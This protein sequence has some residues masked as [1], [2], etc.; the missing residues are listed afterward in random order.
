M[1][2]RNLKAQTALLFCLITLFSYVQMSTP[3]SGLCEG[4]QLDWVGSNTTTSN[5]DIFRMRVTMLYDNGQINGW[6]WDQNG[7]V[8][9]ETSCLTCLTVPTYLFSSRLGSAAID[10]YFLTYMDG[11]NDL[12]TDIEGIGVSVERHS[13]SY[14]LD[15]TA[16]NY[17][18]NITY[19]VEAND[20]FVLTSITEQDLSGNVNYTW[21]LESSVP[22]HTCVGIYGEGGSEGS[23]DAITGQSSGGLSSITAI[24]PEIFSSPITILYIIGLFGFFTV[25]KKRKS[26]LLNESEK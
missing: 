10:I 15:C 7:G 22:G 26:K 6:Y 4:T 2:I 11:I 13:S 17:I 12:E 21:V 18:A 16:A 8:H 24:G 19:R 23:N 5:F 20:L 14:Q 25:M 9:N 1:K 3:V